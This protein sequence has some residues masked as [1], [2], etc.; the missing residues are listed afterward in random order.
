MSE[1]SEEANPGDDRIVRAG[2]IAL[3]L[4]GQSERQRALANDPALAREVNR[5]EDV[6][7]ELAEALAPVPPPPRVWA[8]LA[9]ALTAAQPQGVESSWRRSLALWRAIAAGSLAAAI[10]L[11]LLYARTLG[12]SGIASAP[13]LGP[14]LVAA[15]SPKEGPPLFVATYDAARGS[16]LVVP[17]SFAPEA[18]RIAEF[19][20]SPKDA[21]ELIALGRLD[22]AKP[23]M[24][25][26]SP[27]EARIID[28]EA[29]FAVTSEK[30]G[31]A[32]SP[33]SPGPLIAH[34]GFAAF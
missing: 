25:H 21:D 27:A 30:D 11:G 17:A 26:V 14:L 31:A 4:V 15:L 6:L 3:G 2:E 23:T 22:P 34:G 16:I 5:W 28:V 12:E 33:T 9:R 29:T 24:I 10:V 1:P 19:W 7:G 18:G 20:I 32:P 8:T 13:R